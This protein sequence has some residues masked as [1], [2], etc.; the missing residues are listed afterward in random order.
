[1]TKKK[2]GNIGGRDGNRKFSCGSLVGL[3]GQ[4]SSKGKSIVGNLC[5]KTVLSS[6]KIKKKRIATQPVRAGGV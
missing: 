5:R 4:N 6:G 2:G 3:K 1:M